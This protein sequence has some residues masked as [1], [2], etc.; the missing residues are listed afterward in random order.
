MLE[1]CH[2]DHPNDPKRA[3]MAFVGLFH[4]TLGVRL[5]DD[6]RPTYHL[7]E[8]T[9]RPHR[10]PNSARPD[11]VSLRTLAEAIMGHEFVNEYYHPSG[12]FD[13]GNRQLFEAAIDPTAFLNISTFNLSVSGLVNAEI[14]D[15]FELPTYIG[16]QLVT[17]KPTNMN[18]Q[19]LIGVTRIAPQT[20]AGKGRKPGEAHPEVGVSDRYQTTPETVEQA[21][22]VKVTRE[23]VFFDLTGQVLDNAGEVGMEL[24]YGKEKDILDGVLG[25]SNSHNYNGTSYNTY[26]T[27]SPWIN[28]H[29]NPFSDYQDVD[30]ARQLFVGMTD[31]DTGRE[32]ML[33]GYQILC[34]PAREVKFRHN[35]FNAN[36]YMLGTQLNSNFP[37]VWTGAATSPMSAYPLSLIQPSVIAYNRAT[38]SDGLALSASS[39]KEYWWIGDFKKAFWWM[40]NWPLTPWQAAAD[41]LVMKDQGLVAVYGANYRGVFYAKQPRYVIRNKDA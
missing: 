38:A 11:E 32:I 20:S 29:A 18:G 16:D 28:D 14:L 15:K 36:N 31:P 39:A 10:L 19:K 8:A 24:G 1:C 37:S 17:N 25:V 27:S 4:D 5:G 26:Q 6:L 13:F 7:N 2:N 35:L 23:A 34:M 22:K 21:L 30:D 9:G 12:G 33:A 41:E 3:R 40:E